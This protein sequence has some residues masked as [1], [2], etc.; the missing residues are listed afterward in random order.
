[1][2]KIKN[3]YLSE[4]ATYYFINKEI[5]KE[6]VTFSFKNNKSKLFIQGKFADVKF[7]FKTELNEEKVLS[8]EIARYD[9]TYLQDV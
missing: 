5:K 2:I 4:E 8:K 7:D 9:K 6:L 3:F 1:M